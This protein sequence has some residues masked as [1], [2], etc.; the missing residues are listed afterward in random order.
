MLSN[1]SAWSFFATSMPD[2]TA[3]VVDVTLQGLE[4]KVLSQPYFNVSWSLTS[5][6]S[7]NTFYNEE[8][9]EK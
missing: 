4:S 6:I 9:L 3:R 1:D 5:E 2:H 8:I 7:S